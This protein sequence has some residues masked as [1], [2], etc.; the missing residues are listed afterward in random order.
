MDFNYS[1]NFETAQKQEQRLSARQL[2]GVELLSLPVMQLAEYIEQQQRLNPVLETEIHFQGPPAEISN[3][4][5]FNPDDEFSD[6]DYSRLSGGN[7]YIEG[8]YRREQYDDDREAARRAEERHDYAVNSIP[9]PE[10]SIRRRLRDEMLADGMPE[11]LLHEAEILLGYLDDRGFSTSAPDR[12]AAAEHIDAGRVDKAAEWLRRTAPAGTGAANQIVYLEE[13]L[14]CNG[15]LDDIMRRLLEEYADS[16]PAVISREMKISG[17]ELRRR[18]KIISRLKPF[19]WYG[20]E[21]EPT[22]YILPEAEIIRGPDEKYLAVPYDSGVIPEIRKSDFY[23]D[24]FKDRQTDA[25]TRKYLNTQINAADELILWTGKRQ[26]T[27]L[28]LA[29]LIADEQKLF[30][31]SGDT[32]KIKPM[33]R[34]EAGIKLNLSEST[35]SRAA[36][37]KY[38]KTPRGL[39]MFSDFFTRGMT[40]E[41]GETVSVRNIM[42]KIRDIIGGEDRNHPLS[43]QKI[44]EM[45]N[46]ES[47]RLSRRA[48]T[49]YRLAMGIAGTSERKFR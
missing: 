45:L 2:Q 8:E 29:Q 27:I 19:P 6:E 38:L 13:Q 49:K 11:D 14:R 40:T 23:C 18:M 46:R 42:Q 25:E 15:Q 35:V 36:V 10:K 48:V 26:E 39:K 32:A 21:T 43:D 47:I 24:M 28:R 1:Q 22:G 12:I 33:T 9:E 4:G 16:T 44:T 30:F 31:D 34:R 37:D 41:N 20:I 7:E 5:D 17:D 3:G